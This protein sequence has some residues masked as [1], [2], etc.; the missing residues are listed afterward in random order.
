MIGELT[1][2][3]WARERLANSRRIAREKTGADR[4]GWLEDVAYWRDI[5]EQLQALAQTTD[6]WAAAADFRDAYS[7]RL[8]MAVKELTSLTNEVRG[9]LGHAE[10]G[11]REAI[12]NTN[13]E[14]LKYRVDAARAV[15]KTLGAFQADPVVDPSEVS[16]TG[17][18][19]TRDP[20]SSNVASTS[21]LSSQ[22]PQEKA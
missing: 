21:D 9:V 19:S 7:A 6:A 18:P 5:V 8:T 12:G 14:C 3:E 4:D 16:N 10:Y 15:L 20:A 11:L 17:K 2:L 13:T 22:A 1:T